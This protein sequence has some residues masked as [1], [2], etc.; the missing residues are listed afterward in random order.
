MSY[1][2]I[3]PPQAFCYKGKCSTHTGQCRLLWGST[4]RVSDPVC[5]KHLNTNGSKHGNC[6]YNWTQIRYLPCLRE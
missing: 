4:G 1:T 2:L 6:G 3:S 5:F